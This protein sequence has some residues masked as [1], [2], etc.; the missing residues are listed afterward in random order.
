M[1]TYSKETSLYNNGAIKKIDTRVDDVESSIITVE[2]NI[3]T[4]LHMAYATDSN[5]T[6][7]S[8]DD[9]YHYVSEPSYDD[10]SKYFEYDSTE[11]SYVP[12]SDSE[13]VEGKKYYIF[14][15]KPHP[16]RGICFLSYVVH[17]IEPS[18]YTWEINPVWASKY[19]DSYINEL[20]DG[21]A[22]FNSDL[23]SSTYALISAIALSFYLGGVRQMKV[24]YEETI[25]DYGVI[26][27]THIAL[28]SGAGVKFD[29]YGHTTEGARGRFIW[30]IRDNGHLSLKLY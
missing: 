9:D 16:Y 8:I 18:V 4:T 2:E 17:P 15:S 20:T 23:D 14:N 28:G 12:T 22:I 26:S 10:L 27:G 24:G 6:G 5:G 21:L 3:P 19:A 11:E 25:E 30:E 29:N 1:T 7:L 13:I